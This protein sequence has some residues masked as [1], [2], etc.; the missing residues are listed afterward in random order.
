MEFNLIS[1]VVA[2]PLSE[3]RQILAQMQPASMPRG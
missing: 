1:H 3:V 2:D